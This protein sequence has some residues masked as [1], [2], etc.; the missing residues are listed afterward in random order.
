MDRMR[1]NGIAIIT[2]TIL[3]IIIL[4]SILF[5]G[6]ST[7]KTITEYIVTHDTV[8]VFRND[9]VNGYRVVKT[10]DTI[11]ERVVEYVTIHQRD[12]GGKDTVRVE[13]Y[14]EVEKVSN[15]K[16]SSTAKQ[17]KETNEKVVSTSDKD[18]KETTRKKAFPW[19]EP[20]AFIL[21]VLLIIWGISKVK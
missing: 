5:C 21:L 10:N 15:S 7:K 20:V 6:C 13:V 1:E 4:T 12:S 9:T 18:K 3:V 11:R 14:H 16:D 2:I 8:N 19:K 17:S